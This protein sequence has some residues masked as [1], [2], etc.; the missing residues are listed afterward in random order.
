MELNG[1]DVV[2]IARAL[3]VAP[4]VFC[5]HRQAQ[6]RQAI[7]LDGGLPNHVLV[8]KRR[9]AVGD[10]DSARRPCLFLQTLASHRKICGL[11]ALAPALCQLFPVQ[12]PEPGASEAIPLYS[13]E[14]CWRP[15]KA[16]EVEPTHE[17]ALLAQYQQEHRRWLEVVN[18]WNALAAAAPRGY[19]FEAFL[20]YLMNAYAEDRAPGVFVAEALAHG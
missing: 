6:G 3:E 11:D 5:S 13:G 2:R 7:R 8:L 19:D 12:V 17:A 15:W 18:G 20:D 14:G 10:P 16:T 9:E 1:R 4:I